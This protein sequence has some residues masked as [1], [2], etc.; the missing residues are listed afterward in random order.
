V[1]ICQD[2]RRRY[3]RGTGTLCQRCAGRRIAAKV[4]TFDALAAAYKR[5]AP[6]S[7]IDRLRAAAWGPR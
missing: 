4:A 7:E 3:R 5:D 1:N 6:E 2:C